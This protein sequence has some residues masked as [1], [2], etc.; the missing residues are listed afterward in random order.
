VDAAEVLEAAEGVLDEVATGVAL[1]DPTARIAP[2]PPPMIHA[3][4]ESGK[5][6][7]LNP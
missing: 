1:L 3:A 5:L 2:C 7:Q 6:L 4:R